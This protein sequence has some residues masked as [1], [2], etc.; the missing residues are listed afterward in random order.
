MDTDEVRGISTASTVTKYCK[1]VCFQGH[2]GPPSRRGP[3]APG[4]RPARSAGTKGRCRVEGVRGRPP[5]PAPSWLPSSS[6]KPSQ[7]AQSPER[8]WRWPLILGGDTQAE[9]FQIPQFFYQ[10]LAGLW[11][12]AMLLFTS[13]LSPQ[14]MD[15]SQVRENTRQTQTASFLLG[16]K[17]FWCWGEGGLA[18][19]LGGGTSAVMCWALV[20]CAP[21]ADSPEPRVRTRM[22]PVFLLRILFHALT[23]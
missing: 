8:K 16:I 14:H 18:P 22:C 10:G 7:G 1:G 20:G 23:A 4:L 3:W 15:L 12:R 13:D 17:S 21:H 2:P 6:S 11:V 9:A 5:R 19:S